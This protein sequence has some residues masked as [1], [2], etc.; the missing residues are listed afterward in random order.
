SGDQTQEKSLL[1]KVQSFETFKREKT[2]TAFRK[3]SS[4]SK[5]KKYDDEKEQVSI[6]VGIMYFDQKKCELR[7]KWGKRLPLKIESNASYHSVL[8]HGL[9]KWKAFRKSDI[10]EDGVY[11]L[12]LEDGS[13]ATF[14]PSHEGKEFFTDCRYREELGKS[15]QRICLY[16]CTEEDY[17]VS[18]GLC[19][20]AEKNSESE[21]E[22]QQ[23]PQ[24]VETTNIIK[25]D[26]VLFASQS[27]LGPT[28]VT[29]P[30]QRF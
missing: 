12:L 29:V 3:I 4:K 26:G 17:N 20:I 30:V 25:S 6:N 1:A 21:S 2:S 22:D 23:M 24:V 11:L 28:H 10:Q 16:L 7:P 14:I 13:Q 8:E 18:V 19:D 27:L 9:N 15:Y 5:K